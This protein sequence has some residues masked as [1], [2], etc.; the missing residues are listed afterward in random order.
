MRRIALS[1]LAFCLAPAM[2]FAGQKPAPVM[3]D[4]L[5]VNM[6]PAEVATLYPEAMA[7]RATCALAINGTLAEVP[8]RACLEFKGGRLE[9]VT[10]RPRVDIKPA[11]VEQITLALREVHATEAAY[12]T[13]SS[14]YVRTWATSADRH[15]EMH[16][17]HARGHGSTI[18]VIYAPGRSAPAAPQL[19]RAREE[20]ARPFY[21]A[22][23]N[24]DRAAL[25]PVGAWKAGWR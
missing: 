24:A 9:R 1:V 18:S 7:G 12:Q 8:V 22:G 13:V 25:D 21:P 19:A 17:I 16:F 20:V 5:R 23:Y 14:G 3:W 11:D 4:K 15:V 10:L 2:A 6:T